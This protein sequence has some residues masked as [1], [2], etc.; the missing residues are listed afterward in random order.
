MEEPVVPEAV[1][2]CSGARSITGTRG[3]LSPGCWACSFPSLSLRTCFV[4]T[5][6]VAAFVLVASMVVIWLIGTYRLAARRQH[7]HADPNSFW[8]QKN[9]NWRDG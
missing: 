2:K 5:T 9:V 7:P 8:M 4:T 1:R 6:P 3:G